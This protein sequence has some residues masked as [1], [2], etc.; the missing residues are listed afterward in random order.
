MGRVVGLKV[1]KKATPPKEGKPDNKKDGKTPKE[2]KPED[3]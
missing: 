2:G 3:K 1:T